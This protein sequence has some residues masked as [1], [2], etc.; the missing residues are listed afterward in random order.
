MK[1]ILV[2]FAVLFTA[3]LAAQN[4]T[5]VVFSEN[6][7]RFYLIL[8]G[9]RQNEKPETNVKVNGLNN[10]N[11]KAKIIFEQK[12]PDFNGT[13]YLMDGGNTVSNSEFT[14]ALIN[15]KG[16]YKLRYNGFAPIPQAPVTAPNQVV[17]VF[18][19]NGNAVQQT[20]TSAGI[21][22]GGVTIGMGQTTTTT[23]G[24]QVVNPNGTTTTTTTNGQQVIN[25]NGTTTTTTTSNPDNVN[26]GVNAGGVGVNVTL[27]T[28]GA[29]TTTQ[30]TTTTT[31]GTVNPNGCYYP[32]APGDF[33]KAKESVSTKTFE[34]SKLTVA[35]QILN[36]NCLSSAQVKEIMQ[37]FTY[38]ETKLDWAKFAYGKTTDRG[39]YFLLND[40][41]QYETSIT[42]LNN[43][44]STH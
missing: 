5:L 43:Y 27:P 32:M 44:M 33:S 6:G 26:I 20:T 23:N 14:Y 28:N 37:L 12:K 42:E 19:P 3:S 9:L 22:V 31:N 1:R 2:L 29:V 34:D 30:T 25:P 38:E 13:V 24:Q 10:Q 17:Y 40:A 7:E 36:T 21:S 16:K 15:K 18:N 41:F 8:N 11:Y 35:K 4:N 39:N